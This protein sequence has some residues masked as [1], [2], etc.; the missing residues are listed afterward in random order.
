MRTYSRLEH[1]GDLDL[2]L[3]FMALMYRLI[4]ESILYFHHGDLSSGY[5]ESLYAFFGLQL[6]LFL[7]LEIL[8]QGAGQM[9]RLAKCLLCKCEYLSLILRTY[10]RKLG[11][12]ACT[13]SLHVGHTEAG[14]S[15]WLPGSPI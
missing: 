11:I 15:W 10:T 14:G 1:H 6:G 9:D 4:T 12:V 13:H 3:L 7:Y 2:F 8:N 5:V